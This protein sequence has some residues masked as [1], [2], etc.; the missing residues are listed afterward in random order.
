MKPLAGFIGYNQ[1][2]REL[3]QVISRVIMITSNIKTDFYLNN[4]LSYV[5]GYL[6]AKSKR[7]M[8]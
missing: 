7:K 1:E 3:A 6:H 2:W 5:I 8:G 4:C